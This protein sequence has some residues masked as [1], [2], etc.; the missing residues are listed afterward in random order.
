MCSQAPMSC[1]HVAGRR[2]R[3]PPAAAGRLRVRGV[4][5][6]EDEDAAAQRLQEVAPVELELVRRFLTQLVALG[7]ELDLDR[8]SMARSSAGLLDRFGGHRRARR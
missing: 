7:F 3:P 5:Q 2:R 8:R 4:E 6:V 1:G